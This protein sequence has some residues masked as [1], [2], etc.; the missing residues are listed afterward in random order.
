MKS[1]HLFLL[2]AAASVGLVA[3][4]EDKPAPKA[5]AKAAAPA[6][7]KEPDVNAERVKAMQDVMD[8]SRKFA[9]PSPEAAA[10]FAQLRARRAASKDAEE[11]NA[12]D[13][14]LQLDPAVAPTSPLGKE[15]L[16]NY[17]APEVPTT[18][19][20]LAATERALDLGQKPTALTVAELTALATGKEAEF[21]PRALRL[22]RR[23]DPAAAAPILWKRLVT[24]SQRSEVKQLEDEILRLPVAHVSKGFPAYAEIEKS[25]LA[26]KAAWVHV[27][28]V[29]PAL[30]A[31]KAVV[32]GLLK[33]PAN[34]LTEAAWD[35][36]PTVFTVADKATLEAAAQGLSERLAPRAKAALALLK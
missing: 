4:A 15:A 11:Q 23:V 28:A 6:K 24:T 5:P 26:A 33:G 19:G 18:L 34:D 9:N 21:V 13:A 7:A 22:L 1:R 32:L 30:K 31:D 16:K 17:P 14:A 10:W 20:K 35:A 29:R 3:R 8:A 25:P 12:L 27:V 36:V 2:L